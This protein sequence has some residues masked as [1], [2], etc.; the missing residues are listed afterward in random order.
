M[1]IFWITAI[2]SG[3]L[4][5][6]AAIYLVAVNWSD[7]MYPR[8]ISAVGIGTITLL[9]AVL[10]SLKGT[11]EDAKFPTA[12][13]LDASTRKPPI[14]LPNPDMVFDPTF[15]RLSQLSFFTLELNETPQNLDEVFAYCGELLQYKLLVDLRDIQRHGTG[16]ASSVGSSTVQINPSQI[17]VKLPDQVEI[18]PSQFI[19]YDSN[20]FS[21]PEGAA[22][23]WEIMGGLRVPRDTRVELQTMTVPQRHIIRLVKKN[24]FTFEITV[25]AVSGGAT[26]LP[27]GINL[28][29]KNPHPLAS[30]FYDVTMTA[31]FE[32]L[33]AGNW[34]TQYYK[35][36][37]SWL[38]S[39]LARKNR[40]G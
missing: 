21:K 19:G 13:I 14:L 30:Y 17:I 16:V 37:V 20:R 9:V 38:M 12:V 10:A 7:E 31:Q 27:P 32:K 28:L 36:W 11:R 24:Y 6:I 39:E 3:I 35:R 15:E 2:S 18:P 8:L 33:T 34:R 22:L 25:E 4:L 1:S 23:N 5:L 29:D 40:A 26:Q